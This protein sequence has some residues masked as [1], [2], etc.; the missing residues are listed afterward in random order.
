MFICS[1][2]DY[3]NINI[4][5]Y[6]VV[7]RTR[8]EVKLSRDRFTSLVSVLV[9][10]ALGCWPVTFLRAQTS[11]RVLL[12][13]SYHS[14][15]TWVDDI[16]AGVFDVLRKDEANVYFQVDHMDT[17]HNSGAAYM[18]M[19]YE[20][21]R[22]KYT[23]LKFDLVIT[24]DDAAFRFFLQ[25]RQELFHGA[26]VVFCGVNNYSP[27]MLE[28][29][30]D[31]TGIVEQDDVTNTLRLALRLHPR[32]SQLVIITDNTETGRF[33]K[34]QIENARKDLKIQVVFLDN[35][36][37][38]AIAN[39][40]SLLPADSVVYLGPCTVDFSG[41]GVDPGT[42]VRALR[43]NGSLVPIYTTNRSF[44]GKGPVGGYVISG[45]AHGKR[46]ASLA[47]RVLDGEKASSIPVLVEAPEIPMFDYLELDRFSIAL[48]KLP[49]GSIVLREPISFYRQFRYWI[50][51]ALTFVGCQ[52]ALI[53][54]LTLN[55]RKRRRAEAGLRESERKYRLLTSSLPEIVLELDRDGRITFMN[56]PGLMRLQYRPEDLK[57]RLLFFDIVAPTDRDRVREYLSGSIADKADS[58][59]LSLAARDGYTFPAIMRM[60]HLIEQ[61]QLVGYRGLCFDISERKR[62]EEE[63]KKLHNELEKRVQDRTYELARA[64]SELRTEIEDKRRT[65]QELLESRKDLRRIAAHLE[66]IREEENRRIAR[67]IHDQL[68]TSLT[69]A[70]VEASFIEKAPKA[71]VKQR[72]AALKALLNTLA[73]DVRRIAHNLRP[74][75]LEDFGLKAAV[76]WFCT[77]FRQ[78]TGIRCS[79]SLPDTVDCS[80]TTATALFRILQ[81]A[82]TNVTRHANATQVDVRMSGEED[83]ILLEIRDNGVGIE[84]E[85]MGGDTLGIIGMQE[86]A[87]RLGG[88]FSI[89]RIAEGGTMIAVRVPH[90]RMS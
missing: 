8:E 76:E 71:E 23:P 31:I 40:L 46:A 15:M 78:R 79:L 90:K 63:L 37:L 81:E 38:K 69:A 24:A 22:R 26:P 34:E 39:R 53:V 13:H 61:D 74:S 83:T 62:A 36:P 89:T 70:K 42:A 19:L 68:G 12:L 57:R 77:D 32:A 59:E 86:R 55:M 45:V 25:Y 20:L 54:V 65:E 44:L 28:G 33:V 7:D 27:E 75:L 66:T 1:P 43:L 16:S 11:R 49:P 41:Q 52:S 80:D 56:Q 82:L 84:P 21:F 64:N 35:L 47:L 17:K 51:L 5:G 73:E 88:F 29:Q 2:S 72:V 67:E 30:E 3:T 10:L 14:G 9:L 50:W 58:L 87:V 60:N 6:S 18:E 48:S 4:F 85:R